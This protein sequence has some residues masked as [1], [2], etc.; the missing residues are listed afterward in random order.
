MNTARKLLRVASWGLLLSSVLLLIVT[1][2]HSHREKASIAVPPPLEVFGQ[3][4]EFALTAH[5]GQTLTRVDLTGKVSVVNFF[6]TSC[7]SICPIMQDSMNEVQ[8][9]FAHN[10][11]VQLVSFTVDPERDTVPVLA[12]YAKR[13]GAIEGQWL[14]VTGAK[15]DI[16]KLARQGFRLAADDKPEQL[17]G[18]VHDFIHS[19]KLVL[20]DRQGNI[21][22]YYS[23]LDAQQVE[24]LIADVNKLLRDEGKR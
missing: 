8:K 23:S 16:Y 24:Q 10:P 1:Y 15:R 19:E 3:V 13:R 9:A 7:R 17:Q 22:G 6:F 21:R 11:M 20:V 2:F 12:E 14:F 4:P 5:T 18:T